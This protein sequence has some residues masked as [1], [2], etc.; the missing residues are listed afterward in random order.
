MAEETS[1]DK[2]IEKT[3]NE[4]AKQD[5]TY[6][7]KRMIAQALRKRARTNSMILAERASM[8]V[9]EYLNNDA[10]LERLEVFKKERPMWGYNWYKI[11]DRTDSGISFYAYDVNEYAG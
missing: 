3:E 6:F 2:D 10:R 11:L 9:E 5:A 7:E 1:T 8:G 4:I